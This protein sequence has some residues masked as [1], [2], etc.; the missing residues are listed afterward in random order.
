ME[1]TFG[2]FVG[3]N[4]YQYDVKQDKTAWKTNRYLKNFR[5]IEGKQQA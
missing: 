2:A 5:P 4:G 1:T 3:E